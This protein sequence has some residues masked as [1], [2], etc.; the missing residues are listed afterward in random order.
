MVWCDF[1]L[2]SLV[3]NEVCFESGDNRNSKGSSKN[4]GLPDLKMEIY[5]S[6]RLF[7]SE[8]AAFLRK[9]KLITHLEYTC[10][11]GHHLMEIPVA[12]FR[13]PR[14]KPTYMTKWN[15]PCIS[16][17]FLNHSPVLHPKLSGNFPLEMN[18]IIVKS[19]NLSSCHIAGELLVPCPWC[20]HTQKG[21][22]P[23]TKKSSQ[24]FSWESW[25]CAKEA[26]IS[27]W[28]NTESAR[29]RHSS[30]PRFKVDVA[31][32]RLD[33][34]T[35]SGALFHPAGDVSCFPIPQPNPVLH[36]TGKIDRWDF[37]WLLSQL[38]LGVI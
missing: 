21:H 9:L 11:L 4:A 16:H 12:P 2:N 34:G 35:G 32:L 14:T 33:I 23:I 28:L 25:L 20:F 8:I 26:V 17:S 36:Y 1:D 27:C 18:T 6:Y 31:V 22:F 19:R 37:L 13:L 30:C 24:M 10:N 7:G 38:N 5:C 3:L 15:S 29:S